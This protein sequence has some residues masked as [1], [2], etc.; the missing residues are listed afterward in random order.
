[1]SQDLLVPG[2]PPQRRPSTT[3]PADDV[4]G[5]MTVL[6]DLANELL[7]VDSDG[8]DSSRED[9]L[10]IGHAIRVERLTAIDAK[11]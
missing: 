5:A 4:E 2:P 7:D 3:A 10:K 6:D 11:P 8:F 1:V 9:S